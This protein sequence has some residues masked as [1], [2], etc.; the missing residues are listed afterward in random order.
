MELPRPLEPPCPGLL[1]A[2]LTLGLLSGA[3]ACLV[4]GTAVGAPAAQA[5][6]P[7]ARISARV[8]GSIGVSPT[9]YVGGQAVTFSGRLGVSGRRAITLQQFMGRPGDI[10]FPV[11]GY[12]GWTAAD[13]SFRV[14]VPAPDMW[15]IR[16]RVVS[17]G[18]AS[19]SVLLE[20]KLQGADLWV[21]GTD[22]NAPDQAGTPS[23]GVP[24]DVSVDTT[25]VI[26][27]RRF[28][29]G[30]P[31]FAGRGLTLQKRVG[32]TSWTTL[33][34]TTETSDGHGYF[35]GLTESAPGTV[36]YRVRQEP[37]LAGGSRVG[38]STSY[39]TYVVVG[40][41]GPAQEQPAPTTTR[42]DAWQPLAA[43]GA[44]QTPTMKTSFS[45][46]GWGRKVFDFDW[47]RGQSLTDAPGTGRGGY[48]EYSDGTG[49]AAKVNGM[50]GLDAKRAVN[51]AAGDLGTTMATMT[52]N[53][54]AYGRWEVR[55]K[56]EATENVG[57]DYDLR[58][59]LVP[60]ASANYACGSRNILIGQVR[61]NTR[62]LTIGVKNG[63]RNWSATR[64]L[65]STV[66][67][68]S[69][70]IEVEPGHITWFYSGR[71]VGTVRTSAAVSRVPLTLR[72]SLVGRGT[73]EMN[74]A[75]LGS[76]WQ[77]GYSP[78]TGRQVLTG[79]ALQYGA[80]PNSCDS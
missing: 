51:V 17:R 24:F 48:V 65:T 25:P 10:W 46:Y 21:S 34:R 42:Y 62:A 50:L 72:L 22:R 8:S 53:A 45:T 49:R 60:S 43:S 38:W 55:F 47:E 20:S 32:P 80:Q 77:R 1:G 41:S 75:T 40:G 29:W 18:I 79:P 58:A 33:A 16:Y 30:T 63:A 5:S 59:E 15:G 12:A 4:A 27:G 74:R 54:R 61:P 36:V 2:A 26:M 64:P 68:P 7:D 71:P 23:A 31:V 44:S 19:P 57:R 67:H 9:N 73:E 39:P 70:A 11:K 35:T 69:L 66:G 13:G 3:V 52:G 76:D 37:L 78:S 6:P 28:G 56:S 14:R